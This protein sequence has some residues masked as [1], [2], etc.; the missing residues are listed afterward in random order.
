MAFP[1]K[2]FIDKFYRRSENCEPYKGRTNV[3]DLEYFLVECHSNSNPAVQY[4]FHANVPV[5]PI[6]K[7]KI[8]A[9]TAVPEKP[10]SVAIL[11]LDSVSRTHAYRSLNKTLPLLLRRLNF[12]DF[13][14]HHDLGEPTMPNAV[15]LLLGESSAAEFFQ[16]EKTSWTEHWDKYDFIW[17]RFSDLNYVT[18]F[19][20][21]DPRMGT[22]NY[23]TQR[24]FRKAVSLCICITTICASYVLTLW[25]LWKQPTD[26]YPRP[27]LAAHEDGTV[28]SMGKLVS[29]TAFTGLCVYASTITNA[30][31]QKYRIPVSETRPLLTSC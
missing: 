7:Q 4:R 18:M 13:K 3:G 24:G 16:K 31:S 22:F 29:V 19:A 23:G 11:V 25:W 9:W 20:E 17:K 8:E 15:P 28:A 30:K 27:L 26:Y 5:K 2:G 12:I 14:G 21:D 1:N 10:I 6:V